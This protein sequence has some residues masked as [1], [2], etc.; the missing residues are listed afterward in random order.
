MNWKLIFQL[1]IF[2]LIMAVGTTSLIPQ[3]LEWPFWLLIFI[4][5][6]FVIAKRCTGKYF[7]YGFMASIFNCFWILLVHLI[8]FET[9]MRTHQM[10]PNAKI[11]V[12]MTIQPRVV[13]IV[14][15]AIIG[16]VSG[17][18]LGLFAFIAS[19]I[20]KKDAPPVAV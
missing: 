20:V 12:Y 5:C 16:V 8:F 14:F 15:G 19:K 7:L 18:V 1:S 10:P 4:F 3:T 2:G 9:F 11:P 6:A 17:L 13:M